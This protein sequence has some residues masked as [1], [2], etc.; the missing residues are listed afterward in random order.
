[1]EN[2]SHAF[3]GTHWLSHL[4]QLTNFLFVTNFTN[5]LHDAPTPQVLYAA[6]S[7]IMVVFIAD[8]ACNLPRRIDQELIVQRPVHSFCPQNSSRVN[9]RS[10]AIH[11]AMN[12]SIMN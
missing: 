9:V 7:Q 1:M 2:W 11:A 4:A 12:L 3:L 6:Q 8:S 10:V 5:D